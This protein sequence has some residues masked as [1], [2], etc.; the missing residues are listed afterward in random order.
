MSFLK[1]VPIFFTAIFLISGCE[2][3]DNVSLNLNEEIM[4]ES[5]DLLPYELFQNADYN[6]STDLDYISK[7]QE[8]TEKSKVMQL[9]GSDR[10]L[11]QIENIWTNESK[12]A[13]LQN[14]ILKINICW[15]NRG[16]A[17]DDALGKHGRKITQQAVADTWER[18]A[19]IKFEGW[20]SK[21]QKTSSGVRI[22]VEDLPNTYIDAK[23]GKQTVGA[24]RT[25]GVGTQIDGVKNGLRLNFRFND[26]SPYCSQSKEIREV[27]IY[28]VA[29]HE[30]GHVLGIHHEHTKLF[31][32]EMNDLKSGQKDYFKQICTNKS[33]DEINAGLVNN[34][35]QTR[36][37]YWWNQY[38]P[39]SVMN[40]CNNIYIKKAKLSLLDID[41]V[42]NFYGQRL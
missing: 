15:E 16:D 38:D 5:G 28:S 23:T 33:L 12:G 18:Y 11:V 34:S 4:E 3:S 36:N 30:F 2:K 22:I 24:P 20:D 21:C 26:W 9:K 14:N 25:I 40:Y 41:G 7:F 39:N 32:K 31:T 29:V 6:S 27:C 8:I 1:K 10:A 35:P 42:T 13:E 17:F 37:L 19:R